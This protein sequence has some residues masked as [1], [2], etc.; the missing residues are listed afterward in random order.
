ML[1]EQSKGG[2]V[3][4]PTSIKSDRSSSKQ[5][6]TTNYK[7]M[8]GNFYQLVEHRGRFVNV[9]I[10][11]SFEDVP[12]FT[13]D[14]I[15]ELVDQLDILYTIY[16][17][18]TMGEPAGKGL[19]N[20]A[21]VPDTCGSGCGLLGSRGIEIQSE[22]Q[23]YKSIITE[24]NSGRLSRLLLHEMAHNFD[25]Y[26]NYLHYL[27]DHA[28]AWTDMFE[29][30]APHRYARINSR[31]A[32]PD[33][34][35]SLPV[36]TIWKT[37]VTEPTASWNQCVRDDACTELGMSANMLWAMLYYRIEALHGK[38]AILKS[39]D[40][41]KSYTST[42]VPPATY[43]QRE[44]LR[45][46]SL[47]HGAE[48]N[49]SCY[50]D[51][52]KWPI[53]SSTIK[54][55]KK[56]FGDDVGLC[57]DQ[58][59]DG[60]SSVN[61]DC[62]DTDFSRNIARPEISNNG[63]DDD[64]DEEIDEIHWQETVAGD[65]GGGF[66]MAAEMTVPFEVRGSNTNKDD[67]DSF[68]FPLPTSGRTHVTLC[69]HEGFKGWV[70][71]L[72]PDGHFLNGDNAY[73]YQLEPGCI[74]NTFDFSQFEVGGLVVMP[75]ES[76]GDYSLTVGAAAE[77][78]P[79]HSPMVQI[80]PHQGGG[81]TLQVSDKKDMFSTMGAQ[82]VE[83][84]ISDIGERLTAPFNAGSEIVLNKN[85]LPALRA[86]ETYQA[87]IRPRA[88][89]IPLAAFSA[90]YLFR[91]DPEPDALPV[92]DHRYSGSWFD[93]SHDGEGFIVE[94]L[95]DDRAIVYWFT[96]HSDGRQRWMLGVGDI[97][98]NRITIPQL[99]DSRGGK[100][101]EDFNPDDV[102]LSEVGSLSLSF[103]DCSTA[104]VNYSVDNIGGQ[105][106]NSRLTH[107]Y[108]HDCNNSTPAPEN[109]VSGS[110]YDPA[111]NGEGFIVEQLS[112]DAAVVL[113]FT[114]DNEGQQSWMLNVGSIDDG[115]IHIPV[116]LQ[117]K[118][119]KFGRDFD[120]E[121]I[122]KQKWGEL[123]L[124]LDCTGG[125]ARYTTQLEGYSTGSQSLVPLTLLANSGCLK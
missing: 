22:A 27:P 95:G 111:H 38:K 125:T 62:D 19:L 81:M 57:T 87:R 109:D 107:V 119:G 58:D 11:Q 74:S 65:A 1:P 82:E 21:F 17:D 89:G 117:P 43:K 37:Y 29:Y 32:A 56:L 77:M 98:G 68:R 93:A 69:A 86:G 97:D 8:D 124:E 96:Y 12:F 114:Y 28:H 94:I 78:L 36:S 18:I 49:I 108:G 84:W 73:S 48:A 105:Q 24:L 85:T 6:I 103:L 75:D 123:T 51:A 5:S 10:P 116:I 54:S 79:D 13:D 25:I 3:S 34:L 42:H 66:S 115:T 53:E 35:Y 61:G 33:D 40:Y 83:I 99:L 102:V 118:G 64:C 70:I 121:N 15:A 67:N 9:L 106:D 100:F 50:M 16:T 23:I 2:F 76:S 52:L 45:L 72:Q 120:P 122:T 26:S 71:A 55:M 104:L 14:H 31:G 101:G 20:I 4:L 90:G 30:F 110:W 44:E 112:P 47:A 39:F 88:N 7:A 60:Y 41:L 63:V 92:I 46:M 59:Q 91:H 113:W 80:L